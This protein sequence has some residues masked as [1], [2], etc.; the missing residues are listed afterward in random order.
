[1]RVVLDTNVLISA[2]WK[3]G[4]NEARVVELA[5]AGAFEIALSP[6]LEAE[7][8]DV[9]AR[10]KFAKHRDALEA[11]IAALLTV[12]RHVD[13]PAACDACADPDDNHLLDAA[14]AAGAAHV[15]TGNL[16][17]FPPVWRGIAVINARALLDRLKDPASPPPPQSSPAHSPP[18][19]C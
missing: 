8:R 4:G 2:C 16:R 12:A 13:A 19:G 10:P 14:L 7:Y 11:A 15:V 5:A 17:D 3:P 18:A 1:M 9:A 6:A